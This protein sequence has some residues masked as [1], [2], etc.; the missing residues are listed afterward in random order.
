MAAQ[1]IGDCVA[2]VLDANGWNAKREFYY[3][4]AGVQIENLALST[5]ARIKGIAPD[6]DGW[7]EGG[8]R[9]E[10]I[11]D[12]ARAY[13]AGASVDLEGSTV[14]GAKDPDDMQAIRRFAVAYLRNEQ[15]LTWPRS[16]STSTST[17]W[18]AR[19]TPTARLPK[20]WPSCRRPATP[21]RK[22]A[23]CGCAAPTS[24]TTRTA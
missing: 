2:R 13:M 19:C 7:P 1:L 9:G 6:Q 16:V 12:V 5:Q 20:R 21:M 15:N 23:R 14:V 22:A 17:S 4:D 8:Y 24:V 10:Y 18:K 3:N 11:A